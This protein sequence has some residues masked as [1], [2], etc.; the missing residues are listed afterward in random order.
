MIRT[1]VQLTPDQFVQLKRMAA[2]HGVSMAAEIRAA[3]DRHLQESA[4]GTAAI[5]RAVS[6]VGGFHSGRA[7]VSVKHDEH[8][9]EAFD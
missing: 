9:A 7:D 2:A 4:G 6:A 3:L 1:Q 8:L 5:T